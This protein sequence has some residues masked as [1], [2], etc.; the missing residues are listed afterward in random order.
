MANYL[1]TKPDIL[2]LTNGQ[3]PQQM[4]ALAVQQALKAINGEKIDNYLTIT[5]THMY[6]ASTPD[7]VKTWQQ[8]HADGLP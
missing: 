3:T 6:F 8:V 4:G 2:I 1:L 7:D 5:P